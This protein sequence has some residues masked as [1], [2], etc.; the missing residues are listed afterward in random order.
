[1]GKII[2]RT[3]LTC[4]SLAFLALLFPVHGFSANFSLN[5]IRI[6][7]DGSSKTNILS[8][9]NNSDEN[10]AVQLR[11]YKWSQN[12]KGEN[13]YDL[14]KDIVF[15]PKIANIKKGEKKIVRLGTRIPQGQQEKTYRLYIEEIPDR[16][17]TDNTAV[18]IVMKVGVPIFL[19]PVTA[20]PKGLVREMNLDK[21][22]F[23][24]RL[25]NE[26]NVHFILRSIN[27]SGHN[28]SGE[29]IFKEEIGG[30]YLHYGNSKDVAFDIPQESCVNIKTLDLEM[31][32]DK[33]T[34]REKIDVT[35][36]MCRL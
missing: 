25:I 20:Q 6:Y 24:A 9:T 13:T 3:I 32:T 1:M 10:I 21:G 7:F 5:P 8:I 35:R 4:M 19:A 14:T 16:K 27:V 11:A 28:D 31:N 18:N 29:E 36:E 22:S 23:H 34:V 26:G 17:K 2:Q 15:F 30:R 12:E 33:L